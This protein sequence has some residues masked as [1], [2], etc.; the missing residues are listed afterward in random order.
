MSLVGIDFAKMSLRDALDLAVLIEEEARDRY[1]ELGD[2]LIAHR[3]PEAAGFFRKMAR[4]EEIH[5]KQLYDRRHNEFDNE[6]S[7]VNASMLYDIEAPEYDEVRAF[8]TVERALEVA[9][10]CE[11]KAH[12]FF[13]E[14]IR[15]VKDPS[16]VALFNELREEEVE[17]QALV[18]AEM[19][20]LP[21][22][23]ERS[24]ADFSDDP[25]AY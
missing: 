6:P 24:A 15:R 12:A 10:R 23:K 3:T 16:V 20:K 13:V 25:I 11:E 22:V 17:H 5:R 21:K 2:Q 14:A 8:M 18:K 9:L 7:T 4:V 1:E 19:A